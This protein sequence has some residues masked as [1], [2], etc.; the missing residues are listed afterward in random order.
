MANILPPAPIDMPF[1]SSNWT[2]WYEKVRRIINQDSIPHNNLTGLQGG[3][4][5]ERYHITAAEAASIA[6]IASIDETIDDRVNNL[7]VAGANITLTYNDPANTLT[8]ASTGGVSNEVIDDR[9]A[10]LLVAGSN[11]TLTYDDVANTLTIDAPATTNE[12][13]D[14]RVNNLLVAGTNITLTYNDAAN[15]LTIDA[16][17]G[18]GGVS[19]AEVLKHI[20]FGF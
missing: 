7:L 16:T 10:S 19:Q 5:T 11:V 13:I 9:V 8:I 6:S 2:D 20:S 1:T 17:G 15:T 4:S 3:S 14:D 12:Q 18:G